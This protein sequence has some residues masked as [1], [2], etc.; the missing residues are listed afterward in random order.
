MKRDVGSEATRAYTSVSQ[1]L[2]D[3]E[4]GVTT[5]E[6]V[7]TARMLGVQFK[8]ILAPGAEPTGQDWVLLARLVK[9]F[10]ARL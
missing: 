5:I 3:A 7:H 1:P 8:V 9:G 10:C 4:P 6:G 2:P